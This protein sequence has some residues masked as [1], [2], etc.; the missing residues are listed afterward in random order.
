MLNSDLEFQFFFA[1]LLWWVRFAI[2]MVLILWLK[3]LIFNGK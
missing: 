1:L 2:A 3:R